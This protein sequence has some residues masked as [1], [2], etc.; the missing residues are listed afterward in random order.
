M[1]IG[2]EITKRQEIHG[3]GKSVVEMLSK[4]LEKELGNVKGYSARNLWDMR[5]FYVEYKD[6]TFLR[7]L[8]AEIPWGHNL[9][10][11]SKIKDEK[12]REYYINATI[13]NA[14]TRNVLSI[15]I[16]ANAYKNHVLVEKQNNFK[17]TL[18]KHLA[19]QADSAMKDIYMLE[20]LG[21]DQP[22]LERELE[23]KMVEKVKRFMLEL[24]YG[25]A[26]I[27][28]QYK[29]SSD[30]K[31]YYIDLLFYHR[32]LK[33]LVAFELKTGEFKAEYA[34]KMNLYLNILDDFVKENDENPSIG[35]ILC[36][37]KDKF[38]VEYALRGLN[39][40]MGVAEYILTQE[41][42]NKLKG[43][44]PTLKEFKKEVFE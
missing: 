2:K 36:A 11:M 1:N 5:R 18:P 27:G 30:T 35:I 17:L 42:P 3:F 13:K 8:V 26:F 7:Q 16:K 25:F 4:D 20:F 15:Q 39:K 38:E 22:I 23:T 37:G 40:P 12:E 29:V 10:I 28:N 6:N 41:L 24:G 34:G 31:D 43:S 21:I 44:L 33:C 19:E 9:L 32:K 14:W